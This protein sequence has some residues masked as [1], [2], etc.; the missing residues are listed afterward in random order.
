MLDAFQALAPPSADLLAPSPYPVGSRAYAAT[1]T[2][3]DRVR[4]HQEV[5]ADFAA[6][7]ADANQSQAIALKA[8]PS[9]SYS[10]EQGLLGAY[11]TSKGDKWRGRDAE[12]SRH[13]EGLKGAC[14]LL[15]EF[16]GNIDYR[17]VDA[18]MAGKFKDYLQTLGNSWDWQSRKL[19][20]AHRMYE[21]AIGE[22]EM[23]RPNPFDNLK[24]RGEAADDDKR[25]KGAF[26]PRQLRAILAKAE[27]IKF[28]DDRH[29]EVDARS[30]LRHLPWSRT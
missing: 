3:E 30:S 15:L 26:T 1:A 29:T 9:N 8:E 20:F 16:F 18:K 14:K 7:V 24:P 27:A 6:K 12:N 13:Q 17:D 2:L 11:V 4:L 5:A 28:G 25:G 22:R 10:F 19:Q 23:D 21:A